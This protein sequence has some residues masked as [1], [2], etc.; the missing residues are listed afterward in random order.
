M[1]TTTTMI[2]SE[3]RMLRNSRASAGERRGISRLED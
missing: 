2:D 1:S 3:G